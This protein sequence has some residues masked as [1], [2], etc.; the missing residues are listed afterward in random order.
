MLKRGEV[1]SK[2]GDR[3]P[4]CTAPLRGESWPRETREELHRHANT[5][6]CEIFARH[7]RPY[8]AAVIAWARANSGSNWRHEGMDYLFLRKS[9]SGQGSVPITPGSALWLA[10]LLDRALTAARVESA[11]R[12]QRAAA[13]PPRLRRVA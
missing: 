11:Q 3:C 2:H 12:R 7:D 13:K 4:Y 5:A 10:M 8:C 9:F 1:K 6:N